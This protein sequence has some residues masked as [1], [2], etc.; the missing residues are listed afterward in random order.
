[1]KKKKKRFGREMRKVA[2]SVD[3]MTGVTWDRCYDFKNI[4]AE[5]CYEKIGDFCSKQS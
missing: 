2:F 3:T 4:F 5:K 1:M